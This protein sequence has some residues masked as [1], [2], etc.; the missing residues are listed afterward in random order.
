MI[1]FDATSEK[2]FSYLL[3]LS[4]FPPPEATVYSFVPTHVPHAVIHV[5]KWPYVS[6]VQWACVDCGTG[7]YIK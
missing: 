4:P 2:V 6:H 5:N 1:R 7:C 3:M